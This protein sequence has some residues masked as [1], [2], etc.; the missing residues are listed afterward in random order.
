MDEVAHCSTSKSLRSRD[1]SFSPHASVLQES[2][3]QNPIRYFTWEQI[4]KMDMKKK[5]KANVVFLRTNH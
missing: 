3:Y 5:K 4:E 2:E 1:L